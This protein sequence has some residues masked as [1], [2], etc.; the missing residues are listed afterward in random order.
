MVLTDRVAKCA[1]FV[2]NLKLRLDNVMATLTAWR[3][4]ISSARRITHLEQQSTQSGTIST[5]IPMYGEFH[6]LGLSRAVLVILKE[7]ANGHPWGSTERMKV[8]QVNEH[9]SSIFDSF[10]AIRRRLPAQIRDRCQKWQFWA[11][12]QPCLS[13]RN[14]TRL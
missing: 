11:S 3:G 5:K 9:A 10:Q 6:T 1:H 8:L 13:N 2:Q 12:D 14:S 7:L 4:Y